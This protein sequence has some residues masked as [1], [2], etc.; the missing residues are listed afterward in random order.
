MKYSKIYLFILAVVLCSS[1][2]DWL[3]VTPQNKTQEDDLFKTGDGYRVALNGLYQQMSESSLY[4]QELTWGFMSV[5]SQN[6]VYDNLKSQGYKDAGAYEYGTSGCS[7]IIDGIWRKLYNTI[8]NCNNLLQRIETVNSDLFELKE[9]ERN[10]IMGEAYSIRAFC[11]FELLRLFAPAP[12]AD[13]KKDYLAYITEY[14]TIIGKKLPVSD[15]LNLVIDDLKKG[16]DLLATF[17]TIEPYVGGVEVYWFRMVCGSYP[18]S[19]GSFFCARGTHLDYYATTALLA[20]VYQYANMPKLALEE[21]REILECGYFDFTPESQLSMDQVNDRN[22][23]AH[24]DIMFSLYNNQENKIAEAYYNGTA[25][26]MEI[27][28]MTNLFAGDGDDYRKAYMVIKSY[29]SKDISIKWRES[30]NQEVFNQQNPLIPVIRLSEMYYIAGEAIFDTDPVQAIDWLDE[31]RLGRGCKTRLPRELTK[32][33]Y[34][35]RI[36]TDARR[37]YIAE[38]QLFYLYKRL[39]HPVVDGDKTIELGEKFVLPT[40]DSDLV[41]F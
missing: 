24:C 34:L 19:P 16:K 35:E 25:G 29:D 36:I 32:D 5:L 8:A 6:Y 4:G 31:A 37:E 38:G 7:A 10:M 22:Q 14:P 13:D 28:D 27:K 30:S 23:K 11:Q 33:E 9:L 15:Y 26:F 21:A 17:D 18:A 39:N 41:S 12:I 3:T 20:R 1:C 2:N 40:P